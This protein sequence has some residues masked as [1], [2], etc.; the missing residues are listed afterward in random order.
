MH[1]LLFLVQT[2]GELV[3]SAFLLRMLFQMIRT[4]FRNPLVQAIVR[5]TNPAILPLRK[6]LPSIGGLDS[7]SIAAAWVA[8]A[9]LW[10][11]LHWLS[12]GNAPSVALVVAS[13]VMEI[14]RATLSIY[15][16]ATFGYIILS[17]VA[18]SGY[19]PAGQVVG[20]LTG[21]LLRRLRQAIPV[22]GGLDLS[23]M[24]L[25]L[26]IYLAQ[27]ILNERIRPLL[28]GLE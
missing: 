2:L 12:T 5:L 7:A 10:S 20:D 15:L 24:A 4:D 22:M 14:V 3:V 28:I 27:M 18:P 11:A 17:W 23:P 8:E 25:I 6:V 1:E 9:T 19:S 16:L 21:P 26:L 13:S